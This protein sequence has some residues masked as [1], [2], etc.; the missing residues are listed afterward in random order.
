[1]E[2]NKF[3]FY[4][5][6]LGGWYKS[7]EWH[8]EEELFCEA[9]WDGDFAVSNEPMTEEEFAENYSYEYSCGENPGE[10]F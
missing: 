6:H 8:D 10:F 2:N 7:T 1:M 9:C 4:I 3:Y 5:N